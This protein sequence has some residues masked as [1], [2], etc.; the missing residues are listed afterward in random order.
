MKGIRSYSWQ[1]LNFAIHSNATA[2]TR[3][4]FSLL[5]QSSTGFAMP[6]IIQKNQ[7]KPPKI[8]HPFCAMKTD[9]LCHIFQVQIP[10]KKKR[11]CHFFQ[12]LHCLPCFQ[13]HILRATPG[14]GR[15]KP[16]VPSHVGKPWQNRLKTSPSSK[17]ASV[18]LARSLFYTHQMIC[19]EHSE[20]GLFAGRDPANPGL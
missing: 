18:L 11:R 2:L 6:R 7:K 20:C 15:R 9:Q 12:P 16:S 3:P 1:T 4:S 8:T 10:W 17:L 13:S 19:A 5:S 14:G